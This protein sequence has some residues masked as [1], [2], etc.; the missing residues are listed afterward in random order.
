MSVGPGFR[1]T[2]WDNFK[3][4]AAK[5]GRRT[6]R[7]AAHFQLNKPGVIVPLS[8]A[9]DVYSPSVA[10]PVTLHCRKCK[11]PKLI[12]MQTSLDVQAPGTRH[13]CQARAQEP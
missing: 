1:S 4:A 10:F 13:D 5:S 3:S 7:S 6:D 8:L 12:T 2:N 9:Y 11:S